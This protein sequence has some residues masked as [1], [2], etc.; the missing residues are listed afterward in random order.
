VAPDE[1]EGAVDRA[2]LAAILEARGRNR[3]ALET[4]G[5]ALSTL[6]M[7]LGRDHYEVGQTLRALGDMQ[8][9]AGRFNDADAALTRAAAIFERVLGTSHPTT[10]ACRARRD[11]A[12]SRKNGRSG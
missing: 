6:E 10:V 7:V 11:Q 2:A 3:E 4:L 9:S 1:L 12:R 8:M 5:D